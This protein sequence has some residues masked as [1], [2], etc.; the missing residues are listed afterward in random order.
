[1]QV[2]NAFFPHYLSRMQTWQLQRTSMLEARA[3][4]WQQ[5]LLAKAM[6]WQSPGKSSSHALKRSCGENVMELSSLAINYSEWQLSRFLRQRLNEQWHRSLISNPQNAWD[7]MLI[8]MLLLKLLDK[9]AK[10][11]KTDLE[12]STLHAP[13]LLKTWKQSNGH[14]PIAVQMLQAPQDQVP[15]WLLSYFRPFCCKVWLY[16]KHHMWTILENESNYDQMEGEQECHVPRMQ[17]RLAS[18]DLR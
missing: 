17:G 12:R 2:P 9:L 5:N 4:V 6:T 16:C 13:C 10:L 3:G 11:L 1:M 8:G 14:M 18:Q 15:H 7:L